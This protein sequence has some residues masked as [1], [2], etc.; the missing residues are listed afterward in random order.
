MNLQKI[1]KY[2]Y[3]SI[4]IS[5][6]IASCGSEV[7][8]SNLDQSYTVTTLADISIDQENKNATNQMPQGITAD[9]ENIYTTDFYNHVIFCTSIK[10]GKKYK[11]AGTLGVAGF[12]DGNGDAAMFNRPYGITYFGGNLYVADSA[13]SVIRK[14]SISTR[15]VTTFSGQP[16]V[17]GHLNGS[18]EKALLRFPFGIA[19]DGNFLYIADTGNSTIRK[20]DLK[21]RHVRTLAGLAGVAGLFDGKGNQARFN[22]PKGIAVD[23]KN[24]YVADTINGAI[25][26]VEIATGEV[27]TLAGKDFQPGGIDGVGSDARFNNPTG[28]TMMDGH[29]YIADAGNNKIRLIYPETGET[30]S[31]AGKHF[32]QSSCPTLNLYHKLTDKAKEKDIPLTADGIGRKSRFNLPSGITSDGKKLYVVDT[33]NHLIRVIQKNK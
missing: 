15:Q 27:S 12:R 22:S 8:E 7:K 2:L 9:G 11:F 32:Y 3:I 10:T 4:V 6:W 29:L 31:I 17:A 5:L 21:T 14:I 16:V 30:V 19:T 25:R 13:N 33:K 20:I 18:F 23:E 26:K 24:V 28:A 1:N